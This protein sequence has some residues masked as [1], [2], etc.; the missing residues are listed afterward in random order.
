MCFYPL[1][2]CLNLPSTLAYMPTHP[3]TYLL[4]SIGFHYHRFNKIVKLP[5]FSIGSYWAESH[6]VSI[7]SDSVIKCLE[8]NLIPGAW[9]HLIIRLAIPTEPMLAPSE[10]CTLFKHSQTICCN[11]LKSSLEIQGLRLH[12]QCRGPGFNAWS[13]NWILCAATKRS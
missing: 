5:V 1:F 3:D 10:H 4:C 11:H 12:S 13:G 9:G 2:C 6:P 7:H 8:C